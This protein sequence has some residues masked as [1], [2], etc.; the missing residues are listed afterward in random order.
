MVNSKS[1]AVFAGSFDPFS[2]GHFDIAQRALKMFD[3]LIIAVGVNQDKK[4]MQTPAER[5]ANIENLFTNEPRISV[6]IYEGL[7]VDFCR[8]VGATHLVRGVR[9]AADFELE[10]AIAQANKTMLPTVDTVLLLAAPELAFV[11][12]TIIRDVLRNGGSAAEFLPKK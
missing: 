3:R 10:F 7:T 11:S 5:K 8:K 1:L 9:N 12:S 4:G 6:E 2:A